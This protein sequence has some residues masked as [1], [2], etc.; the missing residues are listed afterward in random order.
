MGFNSGLEGLNMSSC[1]PCIVRRTGLCSD[2]KNMSQDT[3]EHP[4]AMRHFISDTE[5]HQQ[6]SP[7]LLMLQLRVKY[8]RKE[9]KGECAVLH[10][11]TG[12]LQL[13]HFLCRINLLGKDGS[14]MACV[15][16]D[17]P[18]GQIYKCNSLVPVQLSY[19]GFRT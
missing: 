9:I 15:S 6:T 7:S 14:V 3:C 8:Q 18:S 12:R 4:V 5:E 19:L 13:S 1:R 11:Y 10:V 17:E 2:V 16:E